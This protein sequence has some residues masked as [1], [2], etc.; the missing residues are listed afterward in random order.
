MNRDN[1]GRFTPGNQIAR[2]RK[3]AF[4]PRKNHNS[5]KLFS[6]TL[7]ENLTEA[8]ILE[9]FNALPKEQSLNLFLKMLEFQL[10]YN[11]ISELEEQPKQQPI[12][13]TITLPDDE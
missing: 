4:K 9:K 1:K 7:L 8:E 10:K 13:I 2:G 11:S 3:H 6:D 12:Q 5:Y